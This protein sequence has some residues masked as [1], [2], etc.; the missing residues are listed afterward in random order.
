MVTET[1]NQNP[2]SQPDQVGKAPVDREGS[3]G[4]LGEHPGPHIPSSSTAKVNTLAAQRPARAARSVCQ[5]EEAPQ[6]PPGFRAGVWHR[7]TTSRHD[8]PLETPAA[9]DGLAT[10]LSKQTAA[11]VVTL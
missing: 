3:S 6:D 8:D 1:P 5:E 10:G 9:D 4:F 7:R 11:S 2:G